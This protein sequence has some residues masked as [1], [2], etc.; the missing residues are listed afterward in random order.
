VLILV[1]DG[2]LGE[3]KLSSECE[4][5]LFLRTGLVPGLHALT[6]QFQ[7]V[8]YSSIKDEFRLKFLV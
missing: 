7:V 1:F 5:Q 8:L 4:V 6:E 3:F 2:L